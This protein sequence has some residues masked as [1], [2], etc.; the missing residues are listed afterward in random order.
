MPWIPRPLGSNLCYHVRV[1]CNNRAFRF[2]TSSDFEHYL[3]LLTDI[4]QRCGFLLHHYALM[5]TH[6]HLIVTTP[7]PIL[8]DRIMQSLNR[9][10]A[11]NY[12]KRNNRSGHFWMHG[13]RCSVID[14][15]TYALACMRY[16]DRN[17]I[18]AKLVT[19]PSEWPWCTHQFYAF[20]T[21]NALLTVHEAYLGLASDP[22]T[23][24]AIYRDFVM[25]LLPS[26]ETREGVLIQE[27]LHQWKNQRVEKKRRNYVT[28]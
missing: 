14:T 15:D 26:D 22:S 20:G 27:A 9:R 6:V 21:P 5:S 18:R 23:R 4:K 19:D 28:R 11:R 10:Y 24:C 8:L 13:Y 2:E 25:G 12:H 1:Q 7:G 3:D 16:L 17:A